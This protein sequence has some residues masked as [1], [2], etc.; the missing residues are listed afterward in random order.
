MVLTMLVYLLLPLLWR[1]NTY[2]P[3]EITNFLTT[4]C[5]YGWRKFTFQNRKNTV[6]H[7]SKSSSC[8]LTAKNHMIGIYFSTYVKKMYCLCRNASKIAE[9][10]FF[11]LNFLNRKNEREGLTWLLC[12]DCLL[13][14]EGYLASVCWTHFS[15]R[16]GMFLFSLKRVIFKFHLDFI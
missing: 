3:F 9:S 12:F 13:P 16:Y 1:I 5:F 10:I 8:T 14:L 6:K 2:P 15:I 11:C 4:R 7:S